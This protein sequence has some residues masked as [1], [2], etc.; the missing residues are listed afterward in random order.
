[1]NKTFD[2]IEQLLDTF[3]NSFI[4]LER[5]DHFAVRKMFFAVLHRISLLD[6]HYREHF[7]LN[8]P[9][10]SILDRCLSNLRYPMISSNLYQDIAMLKML[11]RFPT[12]VCLHSKKKSRFPK[13]KNQPFLLTSGAFSIRC[14]SKPVFDCR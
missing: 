11:N 8:W 4:F 14:K 13:M 2:T 7:Q 9:C 12:R 6:R 5:K 3:T 1:M 10:P